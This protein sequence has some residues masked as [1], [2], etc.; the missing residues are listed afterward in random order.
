[1]DNRHVNYFLVDL[2][3]GVLEVVALIERWDKE[4]AATWILDFRLGHYQI[5][6]SRSVGGADG[7]RTHGLCVANAAPPVSLTN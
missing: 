4:R 2:D 6:D 7:T 1:M 5:F 3:C